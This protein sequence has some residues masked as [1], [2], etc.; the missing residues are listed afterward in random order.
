MATSELAEDINNA[1]SQGWK[2]PIRIPSLPEVYRTIPVPANA[3]TWRRFLAFFGP[4]YLIAVGYM[5]PGNWATDISGGSVYNYA[6][7]SVIL[8]S[9]FTA[10]YL[11]ALAAKLGIVT[12][13]DLAQA[14]HDAY[15]KPL[16]IFLWLSAEIGIVACD[17]A[18]VIGAGIALNL[19]F[20]IPL[21]IG[22]S[23]TA[24]DVLIV[25]ALQG[26]GF[27]YV[28][29]LVI[30]L[31]FTMMVIFGLEMCYSHPDWHAAAWGFIPQAKIVTNPAELYIALGILGATVMP[32]NL[33][34]HSSIVQTRR[35]GRAADDLKGA[36][37]SAYTDSTI[38]LM[39]AL[40][41]NAAILVLAAAVFFR[42]GHH[43][44][45]DIQS[46]Y[47]L[48]TPLMGV[49]IATPLFAIALL[50]SGQNSTLT[51]TLAGQIIL[52]GF[53]RFRIPAWMRRAI[54]RL[55]AIIPTLIVVG[56]YGMSG[57][58]QL[59]IFSQVVLSVQL[60]FAVVP[61]VQFTSDKQKMG[62]FVNG[63]ATQ[64]TGWALAA[65]IFGLNSYLVYTTICPSA[66]PH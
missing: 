20:H 54:S 36:I 13:R 14:C 41:V 2:A 47:K 48:L 23:L 26:K 11:Q 52:E 64:A 38:A 21:I 37:K 33:Y 35:Y 7:L 19:L 8:L 51:G 65:V 5:D 4:G 27:R 28:E 43:E 66:A 17:I 42:T 18:E 53:T 63:W 25:L 58:G 16:G 30:T 31:I 59:L 6:L 45:G 46:A 12:G 9:N 1:Q 55:L 57:T 62:Q 34:L 22:C 32:H 3:S 10:I 49:G 44:V 29:A 40:F 39:L 61:L 60:S 24:L 56:H 50:A 15:S